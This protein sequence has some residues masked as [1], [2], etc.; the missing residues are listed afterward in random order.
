[1]RFQNIIQRT[2]VFPNTVIPNFIFANFICK[3]KVFFKSFVR[4]NYQKT[5]PIHKPKSIEFSQ[6]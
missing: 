6:R 2:Y 1:M 5:V 4:I 3:L